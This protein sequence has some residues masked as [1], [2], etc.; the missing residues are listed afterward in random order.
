MLVVFALTDDIYI[1][2]HAE[3]NQSTIEQ[4]PTGFSRI[5]LDSVGFI[6][7]SKLSGFMRIQQDST[8][9]SR[10]HQDSAGFTRIQRIQKDSIEFERFTRIQ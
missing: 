4:D 10:V 7:V 9:F 1:Y 5:Q 2:I 6:R 3:R 8:G